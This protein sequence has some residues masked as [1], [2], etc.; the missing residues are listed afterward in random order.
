[1]F[2]KNGDA[3]NGDGWDDSRLQRRLADIYPDFFMSS[4]ILPGCLLFSLFTHPGGTLAG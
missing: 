4:G 2:Y 1:M 3:I